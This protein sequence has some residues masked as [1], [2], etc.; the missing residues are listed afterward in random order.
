ML[1]AIRLRAASASIAAAVLLL[2]CGQANDGGS[3]PS[4]EESG[5]QADMEE[6]QESEESPEEVTEDTDMDDYGCQ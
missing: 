3:D 2:G 6:T 5:D 4:P 1:P